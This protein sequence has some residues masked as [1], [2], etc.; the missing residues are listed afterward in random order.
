M[1]GSHL[2]DM[3]T[4]PQCCQ[5]QNPRGL[6]IELLLV[7]EKFSSLRQPVLSYPEEGYP[8]SGLC[9]IA[10]LF[11]KQERDLLTNVEEGYTLNA[12]ESRLEYY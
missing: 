5:E 1:E 6:K 10:K 9:R 8:K 2:K 12:R 4:K 3:R 7:I 11:A